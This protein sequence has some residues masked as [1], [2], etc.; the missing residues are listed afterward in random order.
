LLKFDEF[1]KTGPT[2]END[3]RALVII[4]VSVGRVEALADLVSVLVDPYGARLD[5]RAALGDHERFRRD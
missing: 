1:Q 3:G 5:H 2:A 4:F